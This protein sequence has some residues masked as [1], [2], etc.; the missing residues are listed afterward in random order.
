MEASRQGL[1]SSRH[2]ATSKSYRSKLAA[3]D[4]D[5][6]KPIMT[7]SDIAARCVMVGPIKSRFVHGTL[8]LIFPSLQNAKSSEYGGGYGFTET[9]QSGLSYRFAGAEL[10][11]PLKRASP[12]RQTVGIA[13]HLATAVPF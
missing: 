9:G 7:P 5:I 1:F 8:R 6:R 13:V 3:I 11:R 4:Q 12:I 10:T 2:F